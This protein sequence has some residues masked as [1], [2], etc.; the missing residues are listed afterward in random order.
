MS[1]LILRRDFERWGSFRHIKRIGE[2]DELSFRG[3]KKAIRLCKNVK[4]DA[5]EEGRIISLP[6]FDIAAAMWHANLGALRLGAS[7]ELA[8]LAETQ[9]HLDALAR[10]HTEAQRLLV[11]D[12]SRQ[13]FDTAAKLGALN[14]LSI[15]IDDLAEEVAKEQDRSLVYQSGA[16]NVIQ[17]SLRRA[18]IP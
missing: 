11:P 10:N 12:G 5:A 16:W 17:E 15:E 13:I 7:N 14:E 3:L 18:Y 8:I 2:H 1:D 6:S 9:R 4:A